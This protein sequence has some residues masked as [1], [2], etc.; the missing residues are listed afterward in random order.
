MSEGSDAV[1]LGDEA[2]PGIAAGLIEDED[3]MRAG[4]T[5]ALIPSR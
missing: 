2:V 1:W 3:G 5:L 4:L